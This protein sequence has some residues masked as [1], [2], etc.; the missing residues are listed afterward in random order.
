MKK[1][2]K[3]KLEMAKFLQETLDSMS[4]QAKGHRS[5]SA[6]D[7]VVFFEK[8]KHIEW[9]NGTKNLYINF[10]QPEK[11]KQIINLNKPDD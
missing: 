8:V 1:K 11:E 7:F 2:L 5:Q 10:I 4:L 9:N 3:V 6:K